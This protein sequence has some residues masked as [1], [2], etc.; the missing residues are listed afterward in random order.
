MHPATVRVTATN[1]GTR[2]GPSYYGKTKTSEKEVLEGAS[3]SEP[4]SEA[5]RD[6]LSRCLFDGCYFA[7]EGWLGA[8]HALE[9]AREKTEYD[10]KGKV[11]ASG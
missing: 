8:R 9:P 7:V 11:I 5:G 3:R 1:G 2:R 6:A 10:G 4:T